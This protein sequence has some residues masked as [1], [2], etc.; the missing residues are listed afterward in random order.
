MFVGYVWM[1]VCIHGVTGLFDDNISVVTIIMT[2]GGYICD[3][4]AC[5]LADP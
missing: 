2:L 4:G 3:I 5:I 1:H